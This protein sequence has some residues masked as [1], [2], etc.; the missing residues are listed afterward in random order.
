MFWGEVPVK[1]PRLADQ[2]I[3]GEYFVVQPL[4]KELHQMDETASFIWQL[5]DG[6]R[7]WAAIR[8][9]IAGQYDVSEKNLSA[10]IAEFRRFLIDKGLIGK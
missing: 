3:D 8:E 7:N 2:K 9:R 10:D 1:N 5:I 6:R 4:H